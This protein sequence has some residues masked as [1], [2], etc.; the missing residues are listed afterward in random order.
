LVDRRGDTLCIQLNRPDVHN[1]YNTAMRDQLTEA[2]ELAA[3]DAS[4]E[5]VELSGSGPS[6]SSGGDLREFGTSEDPV[7]AHL[8]R[9]TRNP[10]PWLAQV[11]DRAVVS[12]HGNCVGAGVELP[13]FAGRVVADPAT[14]FRLPELAMGLIPGAGGTVSLPRRIGRPRT[15]Y[16]AIAGVTID[17]ATARRWGLVD[18]I[19]NRAG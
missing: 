3:A 15:A 9:T 17:A 10:A 1:A 16:L 11:A 7:L 18:E 8:V 2:L 19:R 5:R 12:V 4:I 6:F 13:G 14:T